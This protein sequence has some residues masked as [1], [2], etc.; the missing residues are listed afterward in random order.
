[1]IIFY[2]VCLVIFVIGMVTAL[3][4]DIKLKGFSLFLN[5]LGFALITFVSL[6][7]ELAK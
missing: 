2:S 1:M 5:W 4:T 3:T 6:I 7:E